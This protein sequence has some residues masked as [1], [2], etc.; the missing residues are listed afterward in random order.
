MGEFLA[1]LIQ[2]IVKALNF[3]I[4]TVKPWTEE[5][6]NNWILKKESAEKFKE[7]DKV[8]D[9]AVQCIFELPSK[10]S[11]SDVATQCQSQLPTVPSHPD[12]LQFLSSSLQQRHYGGFYFTDCFHVFKITE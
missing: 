12:Q 7:K 1:S 8:S 2:Q 4:F 5:D 10:A 3:A 11:V 9:V 6:E